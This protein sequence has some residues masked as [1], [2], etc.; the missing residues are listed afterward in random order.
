MTFSCG[1]PAAVRVVF[2]FSAA[3]AF[4]ISLQLFGFGYHTLAFL[5]LTIDRP[6]CFLLRSAFLRGVNILPFF[7][8]R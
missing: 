3:E 4:S 7:S 5:G 1:S 8:S 6:P 2:S